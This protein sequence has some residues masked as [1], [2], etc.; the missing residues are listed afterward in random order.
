M[1]LYV[2]SHIIYKQWH[3]S[4]FI[5]NLYFFFLTLFSWLGSPTQ[6]WKGIQLW[7]EY[8]PVLRK[9]FTISLLTGIFAVY[10]L[11]S[12]FLYQIAITSFQH[13][14]VGIFIVKGYCF[15]F[16]YRNE[17]IIF[18]FCQYGELYWL[19]NCKWTFHS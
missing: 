16:I 11:V 2:H 15:P 13:S 12:N 1:L 17:H 4:F 10:F 8:V 6:Y 19:S 14:Q 5:S 9:T 3:Y 7:N 18:L